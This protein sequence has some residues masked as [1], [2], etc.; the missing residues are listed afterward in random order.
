MHGCVRAR[1][2]GITC[3]QKD[4]LVH[5]LCYD[6]VNILYYIMYLTF[7]NSIDL[8][9]NLCVCGCSHLR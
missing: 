6:A 7:C 5:K 4:D 1:V 3:R 9:I 2:C 8:F